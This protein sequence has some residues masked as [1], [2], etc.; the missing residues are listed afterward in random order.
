MSKHKDL[1]ICA[2]IKQYLCG[3]FSHLKLWVALDNMAV[4]SAYTELKPDDATF[5]KS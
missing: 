1:Q 2:Q 4:H 3:I 5:L